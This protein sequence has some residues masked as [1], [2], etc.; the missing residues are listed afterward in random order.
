MQEN[1]TKLL[2]M[3]NKSVYVAKRGLAGAAKGMN[4]I[5]AGLIDTWQA[6]DDYDRE[7]MIINLVNSKIT[8]E[9]LKS[10]AA[11][12]DGRY[13]LREVTKKAMEERNEEKVEAY[14]DAV[15]EG[16][17]SK[18]VDWSETMVRVIY[19]LTNAE[20]NIIGILAEC[21]K[22]GK[23]LHGGLHIE[24]TDQGNWLKIEDDI[25]MEK[26]T[27]ISMLASRG[28]LVED[29]LGE[30]FFSGGSEKKYELSNF[31]KKIWQYFQK[32]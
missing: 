9:D 20:L 27:V 16:I 26:R 5:L 23:F 31:G 2:T 10:F 24:S 14:L 32:K 6:S 28:I 8:L 4:F 3:P 21:D 19:E 11:T 18:S 12:K 22:A 17:R 13:F 30:T 29:L 7:E 1:E 15:A 25:S